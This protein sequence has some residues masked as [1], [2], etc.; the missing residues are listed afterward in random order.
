MNLDLIITRVF[1]FRYSSPYLIFLTM[2]EIIN[3][4]SLLELTIYSTLIFTLFYQ[5]VLWLYYSAI[6][7]HRHKSRTPKDAPPPAVSIIVILSENSKWFAQSGIETLLEQDYDGDWEIIMVNDCAGGEL[8]D[9]LEM[10]CTRN[11]RL[12]YTEL[13]KD[14]KFP[15]SRKIPLLIGM[16][17]AKYENMLFADP[18]A[19]PKSKRWIAMMVKGFKGGTIVL[20]Y[21]GFVNK[22]NG[23]IRSSRL[24]SSVRWLSAAIHNRTYRGIYS[25]L[26]YTKSSFFESRGFTHLNLPIGE[27]D[28]YIQKIANKDNVSII[29]NPLCT[30]QQQPLG[31]LGWWFN[32]QRYRTYAFKFY[33]FRVKFSIFMELFTKLLFFGSVG[34]TIYMSLNGMMWEWSWAGAAFLFI[35]RELVMIFSLRKVAKRLGERGILGSFLMYDLINPFTEMLLAISRRLRPSSGLRVRI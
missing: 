3:E 33:P 32:D 6:A 35:I 14:P 7:K 24:M 2:L 31:G 28:L 5:V 8:S 15:H 22:C 26:G 1:L 20:G 12:S 25:N 17:K 27:D 16:K 10:L 9:D 4:L 29:L 21:T 30:M 19:L 34:A 18:V 13:K 11:P 23:L